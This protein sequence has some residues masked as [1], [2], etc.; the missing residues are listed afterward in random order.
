MIE[1]FV[2]RD[3]FIFF[4]YLRKKLNQLNIVSFELD[5]KFTFVICCFDRINSHNFL[6]LYNHIRPREHQPILN[7]IL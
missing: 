4:T 2:K 6:S 7:W 1:Y 5:F 3:S